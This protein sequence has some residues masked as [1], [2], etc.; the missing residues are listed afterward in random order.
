MTAPLL[1]AD[2]CPSCQNVHGQPTDWPTCPE[3]GH[4]LYVVSGPLKTGMWTYACQAPKCSYTQYQREKATMTATHDASRAALAIREGQTYW[5]D[6]QLA[7]LQQLGIRD[8]TKADMRVFMHYCQKTGLDPFA[9]QIYMIGRKMK[10]GS[11]RQTIQVGIDGFRVIAQ[12]A[13]RRDG[14]VLSYGDTVWYD[15]TGQPYDV[16]V[17][18]DPP[19]AAKVTVY[20]DGKPFP[21]I[22]RF[23]SFAAY[24]KDGKLTGLWPVMGDHLIAKCA[25]AQA[26]RRAFPQDLEGLLTPDETDAAPRRAPHFAAQ[27]VESPAPR[28]Q[29][30]EPAPEPPEPDPEYLKQV[31]GA[32]F[33]RLGLDGIDNAEERD[34]YLRLLT[35][36]EDLAALT[37]EQLARAVADLE[38]C[39]DIG[40]LQYITGET[41]DEE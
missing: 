28:R 26:L 11:T 6:Q 4:W 31:I 10:D 41:G 22:A 7:A 13:A 24:G 5:D 2:R 33:R 36:E 16:W 3:H 15:G 35:G 25:E 21:G 19:A 8:V 30:R 23:A 18:P 9:R 12:R 34:A 38:S 17:Y 40:H 39:D 32:Q 14:A 20:R 1:A 37:I 27:Q 29:R